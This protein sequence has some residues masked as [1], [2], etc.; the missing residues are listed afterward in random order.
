[1]L[2]IFKIGVLLLAGLNLSSCNSQ[3]IK[4][5]TETLSD[6]FDKSMPFFYKMPRKLSATDT[7]SAF[8][9]KGQKILLTGTVYQI[10]GKT[11]ASNIILYY[12]QTNTEGIYATKQ[13]EE[14][15]MPKNKLGQTHGYIRGWLKTNELGNYSIYTIQPKA[16]P[17]RDQPAHIH[18]TVKEKNMEEPYYIDDFVFDND[19]LLTSKRRKN[20]ENRGGSGVIRFVQKDNMWIGERNIILGLNIPDYPIENIYQKSSGKSIGEDIISFTPFHAYGAD[21]GTITCPIC[22]YGWYHGILYFVGS[23]PNWN[24]I[25]DWLAFLDSENQKREEYLKVYFIYGNDLNYDKDT[26]M[27]KLEKLGN[28]LGL[29]KVALTFVPSFNDKSSE[30]NLNKIDPNTENTFL[31]YKRSKVIDKFVDLKPNQENFKKIINRLDK[32]ANEYFKLSRPKKE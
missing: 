15:N 7:S 25:K 19:S 2:Q 9:E 24:E 26:R 30:V 10:D 23:K 12:Y 16:Y 20:M 28:E 18:I 6:D 11:P 14:R 22:K 29:K 13:S 3:N 31:I 4:K 21:K 27:Q 32:S 1:M 5:E 8:K 17:S